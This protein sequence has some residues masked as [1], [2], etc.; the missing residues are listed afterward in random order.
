MKKNILRLFY[1]VIVSGTVISVIT[2]TSEIDAK[3]SGSHQSSTGAPGEE[4]CSIS[5]CH[6]MGGPAMLE[7]D[8]GKVSE[9]VIDGLGDSYEIGKKYNVTLR[10][11]RPGLK[12]A[13]F[14]ITAL[15]PT[16]NNAGRLDPLAGSKREQLQKSTIFGFERRYIT[17]QIDGTKPNKK[18]T[19]EWKFTWQAPPLDVGKITFYYA[20]NLA[21][22]DNTNKNDTILR[23]EISINSPTSSVKDW[24]I[25]NGHTMSVHPNPV[26]E[27]LT[28]GNVDK[29]TSVEI[30]N[31]IGE[32]VKEISAHDNSV[33]Q[34]VN[35]SDLRH[36]MYVVK[37]RTDD[38]KEYRTKFIKK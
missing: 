38:K 20:M 13:G 5:G 25:V 9:L 1:G 21:N 16:Y 29:I 37:V 24:E 11:V 8:F 4:T 2:H 10:F 23:N 31:S 17:H 12:R 27:V 36:G 18:D 6:G 28:L 22:F 30:L 7:K 15:D 33:L 19:I 26:G 32:K 34:S 14:Q 3:A 35:V